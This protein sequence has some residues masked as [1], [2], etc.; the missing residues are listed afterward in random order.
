MLRPTPT[1]SGLNK[2]HGIHRISA[3]QLA[4]VIAVVVEDQTERSLKRKLKASTDEFKRHIVE[5]KVPSSNGKVHDVYLVHVESYMAHL[6]QSDGFFARV[7]YETAVKAAGAPLTPVL[8]FDE[9]TPG[10]VIAP[11]NQRKSYVVYFSLK[12]FGGWLT[13]DAAWFSIA[14]IRNKSLKCIAGQ[15][16]GF[17]KAVIQHV[18]NS[19]CKTG[20]V[21]LKTRTQT[22]WFFAKREFIYLS[23][24]AAMKAMLGCKGASGLKPCFKCKNVLY[25]AA[26]SQARN[27][28]FTTTAE[29]NPSKFDYQTDEDVDIILANL[30]MQQPRLQKG[31]FE[32]LQTLSGFTLIEH[33]LLADHNLKA[34]VKLNNCLFDPMHIYLSNGI[35]GSELCSF[36][37]SLKKKSDLTWLQFQNFVCASWKPCSH[38]SQKNMYLTL[39]KLSVRSKFVEKTDHYKGSA[40]ALLGL[41]PFLIYFVNDIVGNRNSNLQREVTSFVEL[42]TVVACVNRAKYYPGAKIDV[43]Q[44]VAKQKQHM[45]KFKQAY[46]TET[47]KPKHHYQFH[48]GPQVQTHGLV[49]DTF[50]CERKNAV[51]KDDVA[52]HLKKLEDFESS[53]LLQLACRQHA[54]DAEK[55]TLLQTGFLSSSNHSEDLS[56]MFGAAVT[57]AKHFYS[58]LDHVT[59]DCFRII[60]NLNKAFWVKLIACCDQKYYAIG[61]VFSLVRQELSFSYSWWV[62]D[63]EGVVI[64]IEELLVACFALEQKAS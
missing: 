51:F 24:E 32:E 49:L 59:V 26:S 46:P 12:E 43:D 22:I 39:R 63:E 40:S 5:V 19:L 23:D 13:S 30:A 50:T 4:R 11:D 34:S 57:V 47:C 27:P 6:C 62:P 29:A 3:S 9:I 61:N 2:L 56:T 35:V 55:V 44:L 38:Q 36:F 64:P 53:A 41:I 17:M 15:F 42:L 10:N 60:D 25:S 1:T 18:Q 45:V 16:S 20:G 48:V 7:L 58:N 21:M 33:G 54:L 14:L 37:K 28:Y 31:E 8:Y 52:P